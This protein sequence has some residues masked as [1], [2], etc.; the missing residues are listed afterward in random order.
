MNSCDDFI[1]EW[2]GFL[3][4]TECAN[5]I[6][7]FEEYSK[8]GHT[9]HRTE[10]G[11]HNTDQDDESTEFINPPPNISNELNFATKDE[12]VIPII[13]RF[14]D[15]AYKE[16]ATKYSSLHDCDKHQIYFM[17]VQKTVPGGGYHRWHFETNRMV[18]SK[19]I[20]T[21]M[22]YLND[23]FEG[24]ETEFINYKRRIKPETGKLLLWPAGYTHVHRGLMPLKGNKY[25]IT[26]WIEF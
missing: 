26:T 16:Y 4:G 21:M 11:I 13:Q 24:G 17:K 1:G 2:K 23:D 12:I 22:I 8:L 9:W 15:Q 25:I 19:R 5:V 6:E 7:R 20:M 3:T 10:S 14:W 18:F